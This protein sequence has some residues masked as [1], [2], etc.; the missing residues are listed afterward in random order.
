MAT[1]GMGWVCPHAL[2]EVLESVAPLHTQ[3]ERVDT[4]YV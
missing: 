2:G 3:D 4:S 1:P